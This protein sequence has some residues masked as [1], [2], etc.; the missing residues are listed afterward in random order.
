MKRCFLLLY[1]L[2]LIASPVLSQ[3]KKNAV[4][5]DDRKFWLAQLDKIARPV[6]LNLAND[7]L[8]A[9]MPVELSMYA[10]PND[11]AMR[12]RVAT[13]EAFA[14]TFCGIAPWLNLE[15]GSAEEVA[16]RKQ[17]RE[18]TLKAVSNA[19]N[20]AA[21]DYMEFT[22]GQSLVDASFIAIGFVRCPWAWEQLSETTK[23]QVVQAFK[24]TSKITPPFNNWLL[25]V[26][27]IE[28]F[29]CKYNLP[30]DPVRV[31]FSIRQLE[32]WYVGDGIYKDGETYRWDYY[33][34][35]VIHPYLAQIVKIVGNPN[36]KY[37]EFVEKLKKRNE[38]YAIIQERLINADG[39]FPATGR[40][41]V[42]RGAAFHHLADMALRETLP[43]EL[44]PA[45][46]RGALTAVLKKTLENPSTFNKG[47]WLTIGL[48]GA[49]PKLSDSYNNTGS[50]YL[51]TAILLPLGLPGTNAFW[52]EPAKD[53]TSKKIWS[54]EDV[55]GDHALD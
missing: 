25:F 24:Q 5:N 26:G 14:R 36:G 33:N 49:Q 16:L 41:I 6:M 9:S 53:W 44:H 52:S 7:Q 29:Y 47:G 12:R 18:W 50:L 19:V 32:Q 30:W 2:V 21:K 17:Y 38:R 40:S 8:K 43:Q 20:P 46:V 34:S 1:L 13:L 45:Q 31:E 4:K 42:Y 37:K 23:T 10:S 11:T 27:M 3:A 15:G 39:S 22:T 28:A 35:F 51:A 48:Y 55:K 54:G